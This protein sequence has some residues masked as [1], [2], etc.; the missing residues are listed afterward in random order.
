MK[1]LTGKRFDY[2][3]R[4]PEGVG[5]YMGAWHKISLGEPVKVGKKVLGY[6]VKF[7]GERNTHG[8]FGGEV[9]YITEKELKKYF[10]E[11]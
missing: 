8:C 3:M 4:H 10:Q 11:K 5:E 9:Y 2:I 1:N 6:S 7:V